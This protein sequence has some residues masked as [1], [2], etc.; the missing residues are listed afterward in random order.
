M[1]GFGLKCNPNII[2]DNS[3]LLLVGIAS[4]PTTLDPIYSVDLT[5]QKIN[6]LLFIKLFQFKNDGRIDG[7][8]VEEFV[9]IGNVLKIKLT[10]IKTKNKANLKSTDVAYCLNRLRTEKG[11]RK[12]RYKS[13]SL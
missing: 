8:L 7:E 10:Q 6:S 9:F 11:P 5:S 4:D 2:E 3:N 13:R 1:I 12:S